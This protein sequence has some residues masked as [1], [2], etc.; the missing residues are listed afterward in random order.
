MLRV[1]GPPYLIE[2]L[3]LVA[4]PFELLN[5]DMEPTLPARLKATAATLGA[6]SLLTTVLRCYVRT[7]IIKKW[8]WDDSF[9]LLAFVGALDQPSATSC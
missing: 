1:P 2:L 5:Q 6:F 7:R 8:G 4:T 3:S 9:M